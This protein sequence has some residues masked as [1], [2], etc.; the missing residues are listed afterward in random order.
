MHNILFA[1]SKSLFICLI[2]T[3]DMLWLIIFE[4]YFMVIFTSAC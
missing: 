2:L 4:A 3:I 1:L